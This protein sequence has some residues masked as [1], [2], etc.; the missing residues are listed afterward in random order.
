MSNTPD[1][2]KA[3]GET[4][5][6]LRDEELS[7]V[8][9]LALEIQRVRMVDRSDPEALVELGFKNGFDSTG[10]ALSPWMHD[11]VLICAGSVVEKSGT[12]HSCGFVKIDDVWVWESANLVIDEIRRVEIGGKANMRS[13]SIV[14]VSEGTRVDFIESNK[15]AGVHKMRRAKSYDVLE[16]QL[17]LV[18]TRVTSTESHR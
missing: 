16:G 13:V 4:L 17:S 5:E 15:N 3:L 8:I 2:L 12:K 1:P 9:R 14:G 11:G 10:R 7:R 18:N 6:E